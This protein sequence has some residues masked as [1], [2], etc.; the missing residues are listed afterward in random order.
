MDQSKFWWT[1]A[2]PFFMIVLYR[3]TRHGKT[4]NA[5]SWQCLT[6]Y[7]GMIKMGSIVLAADWC[8]HHRCPA[9]GL[10]LIQVAYLMRK[11]CDTP[12]SDFSLFFSCHFS[13]FLLSLSHSIPLFHLPPSL[14]LPLSSLPLS[15]WAWFYNK[16]V[17][18]FYVYNTFHYMPNMTSS[19]ISCMCM[20]YGQRMYAT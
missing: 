12:G 1:F 9:L 20:T 8:S 15:G 11:W 17:E 16:A 5:C 19:C 13:L 14:S 4:I 6:F 18:A 3:V 2:W 7:D 10:M